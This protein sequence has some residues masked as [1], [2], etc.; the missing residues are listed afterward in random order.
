M[1][2]PRNAA[3]LRTEH[4]CSTYEFIAN[5]YLGCHVFHGMCLL[6][7]LCILF[8]EIMVLSSVNHHGRKH[9]PYRNLD[10]NSHN[11]T[12]AAVTLHICLL[13]KDGMWLEASISRR[14]FL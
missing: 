4:T 13:L 8:L 5:N 10:N 1:P 3:L 12:V 11:V 6:H 9:N 2:S 14:I 7:F